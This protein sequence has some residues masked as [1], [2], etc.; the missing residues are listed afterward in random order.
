MSGLN[1]ALRAAFLGQSWALENN[2]TISRCR[3]NC[4]MQSRLLLLPIQRRFSIAEVSVQVHR[5]PSVS[6]N[7]GNSELGWSDLEGGYS[8]QGGGRWM[9]FHNLNRSQV[10]LGQWCQE[11]QPRGHQNVSVDTWYFTCSLLKSRWRGFCFEDSDP[12]DL[13]SDPHPSASNAQTKHFQWNITKWLN[14][15]LANVSASC[16]WM[17]S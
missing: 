15:S 13:P 4:R 6:V 14:P 10:R 1:H 17:D 9:R 16:V 2:P 8:Q 11:D 5:P 3:H 7:E 12:W